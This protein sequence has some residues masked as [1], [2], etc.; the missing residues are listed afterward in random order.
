MPDLTG[1]MREKESSQDAYRCT[2]PGTGTGTQRVALEIDGARG[3]LR[4]LVELYDAAG[5]KL[6]LAS[7]MTNGTTPQQRIELSAEPGAAILVR[8]WPNSNAMAPEPYT[9]TISATPDGDL[10]GM[11]GAEVMLTAKVKPG[12]YVIAVDDINGAIQTTE[13]RS[14]RLTATVR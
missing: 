10:G 7:A 9:I 1:T 13:L 14:Y 5:K 6:H 4:T 3:G 12:S 8:T 2:V 11:P